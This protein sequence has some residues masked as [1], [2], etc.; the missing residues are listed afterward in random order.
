[1]G[2]LGWIGSACVF[3]AIYIIYLII[4]MLTWAL[5]GIANKNRQTKEKRR[6]EREMHR[7]NKKIDIF[8]L[9]IAEYDAQIQRDLAKHDAVMAE[10]EEQDRKERAA[11]EAM[12]AEWEQE[13]RAKEK[14]AERRKSITCRFT[15]G[16]SQEQFIR[17]VNSITKQIKRICDT[18]VVGPIVYCT[19]R[20]QS[21][22]TEW[23]FKIDYNDYGHLTGQYWLWSENDDSNIPEHVATD[24]RSTILDLREELLQNKERNNGNAKKTMHYCP[25]CGKNND[26]R[27]P[28][29]CTY[30]GAKLQ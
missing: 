11:F 28:K 6:R 12:I 10:Y 26:Y 4:K 18:T 29:Y 21:K 5:S 19:V 7:R 22:L 27:N 25:R 1:M 2:L 13:R 23:D 14:E 3:V 16:I 9:E 24:I 30:C 17:I 8:D 15:E 20:S